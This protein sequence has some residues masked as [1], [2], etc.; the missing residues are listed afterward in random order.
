MSTSRPLKTAPIPPWAI[1]PK[2]CSR[3]A[4]GR[5]GHLGRG[6]LDDR[7][8]DDV[9]GLEQEDAWDGAYRGGKGLQ[10]A[11][12]AGEIH[13]GADLPIAD[14]P[15]ASPSSP[16]RSRQRE[17]SPRGEWKGRSPPHL[18]Q[19]SWPAMGGSPVRTV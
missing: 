18:G 19:R 11:H 15:I 17:Q 7:A 9:V 12:R 10:H 3:R 14:R 16:A 6:G 13:R 1:S 4:D 2:S 8:G 5:L